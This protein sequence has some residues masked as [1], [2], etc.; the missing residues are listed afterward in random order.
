MTN[1]FQLI[2]N[3]CKATRISKTS[4]ANRF[5]IARGRERYR[6]GN[7]SFSANPALWQPIDN[8]LYVTRHDICGLI[9]ARAISWSQGVIQ[10]PYSWVL[11][12]ISQGPYFGEREIIS[13]IV[14]FIR[15]VLTVRVSEIIWNTPEYSLVVFSTLN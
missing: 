9:P 14:A 15:N 12:I 6:H 1:S 10:E 3:F 5:K 11:E 7:R 8:C 13:A 2:V 4:H